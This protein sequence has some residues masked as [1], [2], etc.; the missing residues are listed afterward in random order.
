M[1]TYRV[2]GWTELIPPDALKHKLVVMVAN[3]KGLLGMRC[4]KG[5]E[6]GA[7]LCYLPGEL[8]ARGDQNKWDVLRRCRA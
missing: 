4:W 5:E 7:G 6:A 2:L 3:S 1:M 8:A